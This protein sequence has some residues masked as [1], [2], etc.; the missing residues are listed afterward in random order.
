MARGAATWKLILF[1]LVASWVLFVVLLVTAPL[2]ALGLLLVMSVAGVL[3]P[4]L[5]T[6]REAGAEGR[7]RELVRT[8]KELRRLHLP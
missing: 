7:E 6:E 3:W 8:A 2:I 4:L 1:A 5:G